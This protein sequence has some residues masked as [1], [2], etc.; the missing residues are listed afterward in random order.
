MVPG[1]DWLA[2]EAPASI[3]SLTDH[4]SIS[5]LIAPFSSI[6]NFSFRVIAI[7]SHEWLP[8]SPQTTCFQVLTGQKKRAQPCS[9]YSPYFARIL[10]KVLRG[11]QVDWL[12]SHA[13]HWSNHVW[14]ERC[15]G[16]GLTFQR[17]TETLGGLRAEEG[18]T[19]AQV[20]IRATAGVK[21]VDARH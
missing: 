9:F 10:N 2:A 13:Q 21:Q 20:K 11:M 3:Q 8:P 16:R 5:V 7:C 6:L 18:G 14:P 17:F 1:Q 4:C 19:E 12:R 15:S